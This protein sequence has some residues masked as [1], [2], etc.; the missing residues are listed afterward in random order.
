MILFALDNFKNFTSANNIYNIIKRKNFSKIK[1]YKVNLSDGGPGLLEVDFIK[2]FKKIKIITF[3][4]ENTKINSFYRYDTRNKVAYIELSKIC[5]VEKKKLKNYN[6]YLKTS[7]GLGVVISHAI[8]KKPKEIIIGMGG[9]DT[10]DLGIGLANALGVIFYNKNNKVIDLKKNGW[11]EICKI[12]NKSLKETR[13]K[14]KKIKLRILSD[15]ESTPTGKYGATKMFALQKGARKNDLNRIEK[16]VSNYL[17]IVKSLTKKKMTKYYGA[18]GCVPIM[19][20]M[21]FNSKLYSGINFIIIKSNLLSFIKKKY[22]KYIV[23]G[24]GKF[25][26]TSMHGKI[27]YELI[28]FSIKNKIKILAVFGQLKNKLKKYINKKT[29]KVFLLSKE[30]YE[31]KKIVKFDKNS[32]KLLEEIG[33]EL[34]LYIK[35][36]EKI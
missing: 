10:A 1:Y 15:V 23:I 28:K 33:K 27:T 24:E 3:N 30:N 20:S 29:E 35:K 21:I 13:K 8:K 9:S 11:N 32:K 19:L 22:I 36:N 17:K 12:D 25:D 31:I 4:S 5:G 16:S 26:Q 6:F 7:F 2:K 34:F 14:L 18:A